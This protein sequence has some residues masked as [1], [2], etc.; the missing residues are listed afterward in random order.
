MNNFPDKIFFTGVPGSRWSG[1]AQTIEKIPYFNTSDR[2]SN[3]EYTHHGFTGHKGA[4]FGRMMEF[5]PKLKN[6]YINQA[7]SELK[8][9]KLVKS[10]D[11]AYFLNTIHSIFPNDWIML[12][13]RPDE[14]SFN[15]WKAA[16]GFNIQYPSYKSY[17]DDTNM[18]LEI[19]RQNSAILN[20]AKEKKLDWEIFDSHWIKKIFNYDLPVATIHD[21]IKVTILK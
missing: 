4:Y 13:Y 18:K 16:G 19:K 14:L 7:W 3:R 2:S 9:I 10:H 6:D 21:D 17:I 8:G 11:W 15:W 5:E 20:F 1:I 12:I